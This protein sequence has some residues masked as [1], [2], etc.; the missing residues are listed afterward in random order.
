MHASARESHQVALVENIL[1]LGTWL[2]PGTPSMPGAATR[3]SCYTENCSTQQAVVDC[4]GKFASDEGNKN[5][6]D[7]RF[8]SLLTYTTLLHWLVCHAVGLL[9]LPFNSALVAARSVSEEFARN[10]SCI[11]RKVTSLLAQSYLDSINSWCCC[12]SH[13]TPWWSIYLYTSIKY[14]VVIVRGDKTGLVARPR[15]LAR[16]KKRITG[17]TK[18]RYDIP[19]IYMIHTRNFL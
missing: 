16:N 18:S 5:F 4:S 9:C 6:K 12:F 19:G 14:Y 13:K 3:N 8:P 11:G 15:L 10:R 7:D 17:K 1:Y 2:A